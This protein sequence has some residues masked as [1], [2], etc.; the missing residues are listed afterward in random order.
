[1]SAQ[2]MVD[3]IVHGVDPEFNPVSLRPRREAASGKVRDVAYLD[4][5]HQQLGHILKIGL[6]KHFDARI[7]RVQ[8]ASI[9]GRGQTGL[10]RQVK[11]FL[12]R[13]LG[14]RCYQKTDCTAAYA[15]TMYDVV[16][17]LIKKELPSAR[18]IICCLKT[19]KNY[20]PDGHLIIGGYLDAW[21]FNYVMSYAIRYV[22]GL[23]KSRRG[24]KIPMI[25]R[26]ATYMDDVSLFGRAKTAMMRAVESLISWLWATF[27]ITMRTTTG[28]IEFESVTEEK[29]RKASVSK[30]SRQCPMLDM[31]GYKISRTHISIRRRN[32]KKIARCFDRAWVELKNTGTLKRQ[33]ACAAI[34]R[35]GML[36][37]SNSYSFCHKHHVF[38]ILRIAKKVQKYWNR[39]QKSQRM[40]RIKNVVKKHRKHYAAVCCAA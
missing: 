14:I 8:H 22:K 10:T 20:A 39:K 6:E 34:S 17:S 1:M 23:S 2:D 18:W 28:I 27:H 25:I 11:R 40:E 12:N 16:I 5:R 32:V 13:K 24:N 35:Y 3:G 21:L 4:M 15:S 38:E 30:A 26:V 29:R 7:E 19:M 31:G 36:A 33:R 37:S 9:P